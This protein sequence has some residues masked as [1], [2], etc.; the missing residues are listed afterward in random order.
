MPDAAAITKLK[1]NTDLTAEMAR[2]LLHYDPLTGLFTW[3]A[4]GRHWFKYEQEWKAWND[5]N[6]GKPALACPMKG[7]RAGRLL[8]R[9]F[10]THRVAFLWMQF[11]SI[12]GEATPLGK[13]AEQTVLARRV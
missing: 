9:K 7:Y 8:N 10:P 2:E 6:A 4:R 11:N 1:K 5:Q 12:F 13:R 3:K